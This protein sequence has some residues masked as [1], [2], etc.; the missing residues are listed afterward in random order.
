MAPD[1]IPTLADAGL[2]EI[3]A[4]A[5]RCRRCPLYRDATQIVFGEGPADARMVL[6]G[7]Q[8]G[9]HEDLSGRPFVGPAG[10]VL[11][12]ALNAAGVSRLT[13]RYMASSSRRREMQNPGSASLA[14]RPLA[15]V[16][17]KYKSEAQTAPPA[18]SP[19]KLKNA[20]RRCLLR[21]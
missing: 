9:H 15:Q 18:S 8:P 7:E 21:A 19:Q 10:L 3:S 1:S 20:P 5:G 16:G 12:K 6:V 4:E 11:E 17:R 14:A 13:C 2:A